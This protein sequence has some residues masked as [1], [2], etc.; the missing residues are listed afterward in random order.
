MKKSSFDLYLFIAF[1]IFLLHFCLWLYLLQFKPHLTPANN[2][3][4]LLNH[5]DSGW[6]TKIIQNSYVIEQ[7]RAFFPLYPTLV[8][9]IDF[10]FNPLSTAVTGTI[11]SS[12]LFFSFLYYIRNLGIKDND[13][14]VWLYPKNLLCFLFF[15]LSPGS[16]I[17]HT[18]HTESLFLFLSYL[19]LYFSYKKKFLWATIFAGLCSITKN[20]GV[21]LAI[22]V[23]ILLCQNESNLFQ[24]LKKFIIS[25][26]IS[27]SFFIS[28]LLYQYLVFSNPFEFMKAQKN[29]HH[30]EYF[31]DYFKVFILQGNHQDK[32]LGAIKHQLFFYL[33]LFYSIKLWNYSKAISFYCVISVLLLPF[34]GE[35]I[36][37]FRFFSYLFPV[38]F[39]LGIYNSKKELYIKLGILFIFLFLNFQTTYNYGILK[40]AY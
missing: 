14:P 22:A 34:Q 38:F 6:Y 1:F 39:I 18:H 2:L 9:L 4:E 15:I 26:I 36:N 19:A 40:W 30:I 7:S 12:V 37:S 8:K 23:A 13:L 27:G 29:W 32:S 33:I 10:Q 24:K 17:F 11:F 16:Y 28:Y 3:I 31:S 25:G 35:T 21:L 5:W 20:Q